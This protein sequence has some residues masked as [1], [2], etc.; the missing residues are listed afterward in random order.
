MLRLLLF[1]RVERNVEINDSDEQWEL[2]FDRGEGVPREYINLE[3]ARFCQYQVLRLLVSF[4][5]ESNVEFDDSGE[6]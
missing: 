6:Q 2:I 3:F 4:R 1:F 5:V